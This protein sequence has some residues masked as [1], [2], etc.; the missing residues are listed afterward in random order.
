[1]KTGTRHAPISVNDLDSVDRQIIEYLQKNGRESFAKIGD[2][3]G[4]PASTVRD[5]TNRLVENN[6]IR[7][8]PKTG[9][10]A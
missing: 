5:R 2:E 6:I 9:T 4:I 1:M 8:T 3:I 7:I 10:N